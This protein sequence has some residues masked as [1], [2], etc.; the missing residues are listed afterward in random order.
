MPDGRVYQAVADAFYEE[1]VRTVFGLT[2]DGNMHWEAALSAKPGVRSIHV[3]HEHAAC[4]MA[5]AYAVATGEVGVASV[6]CGPGLT[7]LST[8]LATAV[9]ARVPLVVFCGEDPIDASW[10][11]QRI[12]HGAVVNATGAIYLPAR[13][14]RLAVHHVLEAF[15]TARSRSLPVV[16]TMP[17]DMQQ[18][19]AAQGAVAYVPSRSIAPKTGPRYPHPD[20]VKAAAERIRTAR[21]VV[22]VA[23]RGAKAAGAVEACKRL[24]ELCDGALSVSLPVRGLFNGHPRDIGVSGGFAHEAAREAFGEADLIVAVGTSLTQHTSDLNLLFRPDQVIQIDAD[25]PVMKHG[26]V[27]ATHHLTADARLAV[28]ALCAELGNG[29]ARAS[30]WDVEAYSR[31]VHSEPPDSTEYA[32]APGV[33]D[34]RD[35]AAALSA[36]APK[37]WAHVGSAGHCA[38]F[39]TH[40]YGREADNFLTI[41]EFG[42]IG[43]GLSYAMGRWAARPDQ[44]VMLTEGDG[45]FLMHI[46]E[47]ETVVRHGMKILICI[48]NDGAFGSEIHKLRADGVSDDGAIFGFGDLAGI[49]RGFGLDGHVI[50]DLD[51]IPELAAAFEAG[52]RSALWDFRVSDQV[53]APTMRR[54]VGNRR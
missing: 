10:Y 39:A 33:F 30:D 11:N 47:L 1:G 18:K 41:R 12:D 53:M 17:L 48:F 35:V 38:Y 31:R 19:P 28:E 8:A 45:G 27:T 4:A 44:P 16:L 14:P 43:N 24:A 3:R 40:L 2:G 13:S 6:T 7:Q 26:Q 52:N 9:Q 20:A 5:T 37:T 23:G 32:V 22:L 25:P 42:A 54:A 15:L 50:G 46:Q 49:A 51:E 34:P 36:H 21:R 29:Q